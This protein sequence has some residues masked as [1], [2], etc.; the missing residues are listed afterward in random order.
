MI[1]ARDAE[2]VTELVTLPSRW[3]SSKAVPGT[4]AWTDDFSNVLGAFRFER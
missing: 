3:R 4:R 1:V 2:D